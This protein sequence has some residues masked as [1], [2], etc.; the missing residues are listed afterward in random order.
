MD[1]LLFKYLGWFLYPET[2][3]G[4]ENKNQNLKKLYGGR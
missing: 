2:K 4:K 1:K 3:Q